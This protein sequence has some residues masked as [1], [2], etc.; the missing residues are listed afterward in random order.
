MDD[1]A[2][3]KVYVQQ[4][5]ASTEVTTAVPSRREVWTEKVVG[6]LSSASVWMVVPQVCDLYT[7]IKVHTQT[8]VPAHMA[9]LQQES[10]EN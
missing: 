5:Y 10:F 1:R 6:G 2:N 8:S 4:E 9:A 3:A 7:P